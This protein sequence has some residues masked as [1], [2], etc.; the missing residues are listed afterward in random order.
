MYNSNHILLCMQILQVVKLQ[1]ILM[2]DNSLESYLD[3]ANFVVRDNISKIL[4]A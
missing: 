1:Q 3:Q 2:L 4:I